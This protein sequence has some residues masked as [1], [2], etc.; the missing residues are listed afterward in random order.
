MLI[1]DAANTV[2]TL[3]VESLQEPAPEPAM[4]Q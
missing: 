3:S 4:A 1:T 2:Q